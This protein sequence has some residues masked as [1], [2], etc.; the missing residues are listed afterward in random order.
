M[1]HDHCHTKPA[2]GNGGVCPICGM[3]NCTM[4][5][6]EEQ[7]RAAAGQRDHSSMAARSSGAKTMETAMRRRFWIALTLTIPVV[8]YSPLGLKIFGIKLPS[9]VPTS[10]AFP[11]GG[12]NWLLLV[13]TTPVVFWAGSIFNSGAYHSLKARKL[14]MSVL[15]AVGVLAAYIFSVVFMLTGGQET[16]F[17]AAAMLVTFVLFGHWMEM[18]SR[19]GTSDALRALFDL[20]PPQARVIR[21]GAEITVPSSEIIHGDIVALRPGDKTPVDGE[22]IEGVSAFDESLVTGESIPVEKKSGES[23]LGNGASPYY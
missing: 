19:R 14:N 5:S 1:N 2:N 11:D 10:P 23:R 9:P 21:D 20:V 4:H 15:I 17:D 7:R 8:L 3:F 22:I 13:L 18:K 6:A 16:F 12:V